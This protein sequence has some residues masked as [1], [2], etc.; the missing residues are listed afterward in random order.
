MLEKKTD[1]LEKKKDVEIQ[2]QTDHEEEGEKKPKKEKA[3]DAF[4]FEYGDFTYDLLSLKHIDREKSHGARYMYEQMA[5]K[6]M[7][8]HY[9]FYGQLNDVG[10]VEGY[11]TRNSIIRCDCGDHDIRIDTYEDHGVIAANGEPVLTCKDCQLDIN[12]YRFGLCDA[13]TK[14]GKISALRPSGDREKNKD[15]S[16][17]YKCVPVLAEEWRQKDSDLYIGGAGDEEFAAALKAGAYLTCRYGGKI[18]V[19]EIPDDP[20]S[21]SKQSEKILPLETKWL[22]DHTKGMEIKDYVTM[23]FLKELG[24][25]KIGDYFA[26][27]GTD[28]KSDWEEVYNPDS[29]T[30]DPDPE[31]ERH[32][33]PIDEQDITNLNTILMLYDITTR[34]R[35]CAF[36]SQ[37][38][39][40]CAHGEKMCEQVG[41]GDIQ[42][43]H[44]T[45]TE[46]REVH[47]KIRDYPYQYRGGGAIH[48]THKETY[49]EFYNEITATTDDAKTPSADTDDL[50]DEGNNVEEKKIFTIGTEYV[51]FNYPWLSAGFFWKWKKLN[52]VLEDKSDEGGIGGVIG[53]INPGSENEETRS[54]CYDKCLEVYDKC[55]NSGWETEDE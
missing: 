28:E 47:E 1:I 3:K 36:I 16:W 26:V 11:V 2:D 23:K 42:A 9:A 5:L 25:E 20:E 19:I 49:Q 8:E 54:R 10:R 40:E 35:I 7:A 31:I 24:W 45:R 17:C 18:E 32:F 6:A 39:Y 52:A 46:M 50:E 44:T 15:G 41:E 4:V 51:A 38:T 48:L 12:I 53:K 43:E 14:Y 22:E 34:E 27:K 55:K 37:I 33:R 13:E 21:D 30:F 29:G